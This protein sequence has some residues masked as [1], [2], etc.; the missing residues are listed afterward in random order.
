MIDVVLAW[1]PHALHEN[2]AV[3]VNT[4]NGVI[5]GVSVMVHH[6][7]YYWRFEDCSYVFLTANISSFFDWVLFVFYNSFYNISIIFL[8]F[9]F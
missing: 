6:T 9:S 4:A 7:A 8:L 3:Q 1:K 2:I 5:S